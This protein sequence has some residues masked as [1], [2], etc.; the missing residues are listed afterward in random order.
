MANT[1]YGDDA[2]DEGVET[3]HHGVPYSEDCEGCEIEDDLDVDPDDDE[4]DC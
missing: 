2:V 1:P 3:C 4:E